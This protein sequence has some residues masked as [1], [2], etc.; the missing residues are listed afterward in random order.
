[1]KKNM[2]GLY[3]D[4]YSNVFDSVTVSDVSLASCQATLMKMVLSLHAPV[5]SMPQMFDSMP[6]L[7]LALDSNFS[8]ILSKGIISTSL[9]GKIISMKEYV[10]SCLSRDDYIF[11]CFP[12]LPQGSKPGDLSKETKKILLEKIDN[13]GKSGK[14]YSKDIEEYWY[15]LDTFVEGV[16]QLDSSLGKR[17]PSGVENYRHNRPQ[18]N[19]VLLSQQIKNNIVIL[20]NHEEFGKELVVKKFDTIASTV[21][22]SKER[23]DDRTRYYNVL[24]DYEEIEEI[25]KKEIRELIDISYNQSMAPLIAERSRI[26]V[27]K[28]NKYAEVLIDEAPEEAFA[29]KYMKIK[30]ERVYDEIQ[31]NSTLSWDGRKK[32]VMPEALNEI[33]KMVESR[34]TNMSGVTRER[35]VDFL[36]DKYCSILEGYDIS[37]EKTEGEIHVFEMTSENKQ[38]KEKYIEKAEKGNGKVELSVEDRNV[39]QVT[40]YEGNDFVENDTKKVAESIIRSAIT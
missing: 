34:V 11:S 22:D 16:T 38:E 2:S 37:M 5:L 26:V 23:I 13:K 40:V 20:K 10:K 19:A 6:L 25:D 33:L 29:E 21:R 14:K 7:M 9:F 35:V 32:T 1:M 8:E 39:K 36:Y 27:R 12:F 17:D 28:Q 18:G 30:L 24:A 4:T 15:F 3:R 31:K